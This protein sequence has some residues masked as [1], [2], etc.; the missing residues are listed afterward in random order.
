MRWFFIAHYFVSCIQFNT[1][2]LLLI[3]I[4]Y[5]FSILNPKNNLTQ[6]NAQENL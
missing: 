5:L 1:L 3:N 6:K 2:F 4:F